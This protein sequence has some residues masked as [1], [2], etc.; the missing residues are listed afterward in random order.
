MENRVGQLI[1]D[2]SGGNI[3]DFSR[4]SGV[5]YG[6]LYD[7]VR[8]KS[9]IVDVLYAETDETPKPLINQRFQHFAARPERPNSSQRQEEK[10][11]NG[12]RDP[13]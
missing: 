4:E 11:D 10:G 5:P 7:I 6:A 9:N 3:S 13:T 12:L 1:T 2:H 8:G